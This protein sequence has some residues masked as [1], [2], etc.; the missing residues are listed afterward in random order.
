MSATISSLRDFAKKMSTVNLQQIMECFK[1]PA[2]CLS[3]LYEADSTITMH[4]WHDIVYE[5]LDRRK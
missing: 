1:D 3:D 2:I 4:Q 5:E